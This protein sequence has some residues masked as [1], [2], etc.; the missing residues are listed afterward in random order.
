MSKS[1]IPPLD[2][3]YADR[4]LELRIAHAAY[5]NAPANSITKAQAWITYKNLLK[6]SQDKGEHR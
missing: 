6:A 4:Q 3:A 5:M 1:D 2:T